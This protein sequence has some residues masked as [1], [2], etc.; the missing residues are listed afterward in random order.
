[1]TAGQAKK[2]RWY[3]QGNQAGCSCWLDVASGSIRQR[4]GI[5][6]CSKV[7]AVLRQHSKTCCGSSTMRPPAFCL[8]PSLTVLVVPPPPSLWAVLAAGAGGVC[9]CPGGA[10]VRKW[11][12]G[13]A[14]GVA[15]RPGQPP[16]QHTGGGT[17]GIRVAQG[18]E[19][20]LH[21]PWLAHGRGPRGCQQMQLLWEVMRRLHLTLW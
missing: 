3:H 13:G 2:R 11:Q 20:P 16:G 1:M 18:N 4:Q 10:G 6:S 15:G 8:I 21:V 12:A 5:L 17:G 7:Q 14:G 19:V 9:A